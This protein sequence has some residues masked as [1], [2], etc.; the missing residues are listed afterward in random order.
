MINQFIQ[1][2]I[3]ELLKDFKLFDAA[4]AGWTQVTPTNVFFG[5]IIIAFMGAFVIRYQSFV[6]IVIFAL[7]GFTLFQTI[8]PAPIFGVLL[9]LICLVGGSVLFRL[10]VRDQY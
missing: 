9:G 4:L 5:I 8:V 10:F 7:L 6:P 3:E 2:D 1:Q